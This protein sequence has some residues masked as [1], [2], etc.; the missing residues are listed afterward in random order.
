M[1]DYSEDER[2]AMKM[3]ENYFMMVEGE[4]LPRGEIPSQ[5]R[6]EMKLFL[7]NTRRN[8]QLIDSLSAWVE[9]YDQVRVQAREILEKKRTLVPT[10]YGILNRPSFD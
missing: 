1:V 5:D 8:S 7:M 6:S 3:V 4:T 10:L 9:E 2:K